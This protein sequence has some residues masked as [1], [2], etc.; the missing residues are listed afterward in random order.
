MNRQTKDILND[1]PADIFGNKM[2][3]GIQQA[4]GIILCI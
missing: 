1:Q 3:D 2:L 4:K